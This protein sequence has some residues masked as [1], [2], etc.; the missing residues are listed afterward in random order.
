VDGGNGDETSTGDDGPTGLTADEGNPGTNVTPGG[1]GGDSACSGVVSPL[2]AIPW[3]SQKLSTLTWTGNM[4]CGP[5]T[6]TMAKAFL[7]GTTSVGE[8]DLKATIDWMGA[9]V[10][11]WRP[12]S[13]RCDPSGTDT[14]Q[15]V[16]VATD[17]LGVKGNAQTLT[18]C[19]LVAAVGPNSVVIF[20]GDAQG[21]N[22][23]STFVAST[24]SHWL[25][26][27]GVD[28]TGA[29]VNDPGRTGS[30]QG[31]HR[32]FTIASVKQRFEARGGLAVVVSRPTC[33]DACATGSTRC[34]GAS[35][36]QNCADHDGDG[37]LDWGGNVNCPSGCAAGACAGVCTNACS[38]GA[39]Q[40]SG[41][42]P[43][44]CTLQASGCTA[45]TSGATCSGG[46][47]CSGGSC[48][49]SCTNACGAGAKQCS[50]STPQT[51]TLQGTGCY[52][53]TSG[54]TCSGGQV[55]S[56]GS[57]VTTC[58]NVCSSGAKQCSGS[59]PQTCTLQGTGCYDWT[60]G[61]TCSGGQ[62]CSGGSC[63]ASCTNV[64]SSGAK[65]CSGS[66]PQTCTLQSSGCYGWTSGTTCSGTQ[67]CSA[68]TCVTTS[69]PHGNGLYCGG[70]GITGDSKT[71]YQCTGGSLAVSAV[72]VASC[73][74]APSG[75]ND[76]CGAGSC[77]GGNGLYC[78]GDG[79][80]GVTGTLYSCASG[81]MTISSVCAAGCHFAG[82]GKND[83]CN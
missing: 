49:T 2:E 64:C 6:M 47:I 32:K 39:M 21:S 68:G 80:P 40:C 33:T 29:Y 12:T 45:W 8:S 51:C 23:S 28:A 79:V 76:F 70:D 42:T 5:A 44:T 72:C 27:D 46:Q 58:T 63:V 16:K 69:C 41:N 37:C 10:S 4:C 81:K 61:A 50:A 20:L 17:Y 74:T 38:L 7:S 3:V 53:W 67:T 22:T 75:T 77:P 52:D 83:Y 24:H 71:L 9:N 35:T 34:N 82:A 62:S 15:M 55:C 59:T 65:Q 11:G 54:A 60:S 73:V 1:G 19:G 13:Y 78:G 14:D 18:W 66:T 57:C 36:V 48:T 26:L 25:I 56:G 31:D 30:S 43:Q